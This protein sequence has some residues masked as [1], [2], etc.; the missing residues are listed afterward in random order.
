VKIKDIS[1]MKWLGVCKGR[2]GDLGKRKK[3][4]KGG[5]LEKCLKPGIREKW[6]KCENR[7]S[8]ESAEWRQPGS[9]N[10]AQ[11]KPSDKYPIFGQPS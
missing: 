2:K 3:R 4:E 9:R 1:G 11:G 7:R 8:H 10:A 5:K 6:T